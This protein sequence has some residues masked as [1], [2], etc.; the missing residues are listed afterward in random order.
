MKKLNSSY[1]FICFI[2]KSISFAQG[3]KIANQLTYKNPLA[4]ALADPYVLNDS[5]GVYYMYGSG[6]GAETVFQPTH[7]KI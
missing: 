4:V 5:A 6:G 2:I 7:Q 3:V 1:H